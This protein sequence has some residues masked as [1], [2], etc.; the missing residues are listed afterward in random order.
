MVLFCCQTALQSHASL[1]STRQTGTRVGGLGVYM[2]VE[3][4]GESANCCWLVLR[5]KITTSDGPG[6][7]GSGP[8]LVCTVPGSLYT[9]PSVI[10][11]N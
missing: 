11:S 9:I 10:H 5:G 8:P 7:P 3:R 2:C 1:L 6:F 4:V